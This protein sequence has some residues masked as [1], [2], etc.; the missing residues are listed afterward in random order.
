MLRNKYTFLFILFPLF[1]TGCIDEYTPGDLYDHEGE[2]S[3]SGWLTDIPGRQLIELS[4]STPLKIS[5]PDPLKG[6]YVEVRDDM[7]NSFEYTEISD[8]RYAHSYAEGDVVEG[9]SYKLNFVTSDGNSY[10]S[11]WEKMQ[12]SALPANLRYEYD[13]EETNEI[14][15][16]IPGLKF[17]TDFEV[18]DDAG[19]PRYFKL[20]VMETYMFRTAYTEVLWFYNGLFGYLPVDSIR[21]MCYITEKVSDIYVLSTENLVSSKIDNY[22]LHFVGNRTQRLLNGYSPQVRVLGLSAGAYTYWKNLKEILEESGSLFETQPPASY[23]NIYAVDNPEEIVLGYF[24]ASAVE[25]TRSFVPPKVLDSYEIPVYC[26]PGVLPTYY[27]QR[28]ERMGQ[29][30]AYFVYYP[31]AFT[32]AM[33]LH[34]VV[35]ACFDCTTY[36][37]S[38][39]VKP[40]YWE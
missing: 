11:E 36:D 3:V 5:I 16:E 38:T 34:S 25:T 32:G 39:T 6:C 9:R 14:G 28:L 18:D 37:G 22:P 1:F 35:K 21:S 13:T 26:E 27:F 15:G 33:V 17:Y 2:V 30:L 31:D 12:G 4:V 23:S 8:G 7:G 10:E 24:G 40:D 19:T 20:V 29:G